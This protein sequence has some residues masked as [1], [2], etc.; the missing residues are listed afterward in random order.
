MN[1]MQGRTLRT[2]LLNYGAILDELIRR[3][4]LRSRNSPVADYSEWLAAGALRLRL[5]QKSRKGFDAS[6]PRTASRYQIK[7]RQPTPDNPSRQLG[8][9]RGLDERDFDKLVALVF[10]P[11]FLPIR[12]YVLSAN[13]WLVGALSTLALMFFIVYFLIAWFWEPKPVKA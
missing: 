9:I 3:G 7:G 8:V 12:L 2:L 1:G 4:V 11:D 6:D 13:D 5:E 10:G